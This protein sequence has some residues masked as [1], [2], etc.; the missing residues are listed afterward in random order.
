MRWV[1]QYYSSR[2]TP[3]LI[4]HWHMPGGS[5]RM[6]RA[7]CSCVEKDYREPPPSYPE[8]VDRQR[9]WRQEVAPHTRHLCVRYLHPTSAIQY[10]ETTT[11]TESQLFH[12]AEVQPDSFWSEEV[13]RCCAKNR[14][15][16]LHAGSFYVRTHFGL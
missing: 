9:S 8:N 11:A 4:P 10:R 14:L 16:C 6:Q 7:R 1:G 5:G 15:N 3:P 13:L 12:R 2:P